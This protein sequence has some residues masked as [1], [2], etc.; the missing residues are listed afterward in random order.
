MKYIVVKMK[1]KEGEME[2][3]I[4]TDR[5]TYMRPMEDDNE[6]TLIQ[7]ESQ[8]PIVVHESLLKLDELINQKRVGRK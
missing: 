8:D 4:N 1:Y 6:K 7:F 5:I 2:T 3:I